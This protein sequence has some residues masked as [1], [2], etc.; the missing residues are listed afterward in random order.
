M[1]LKHHVTIGRSVLAHPDG[2]HR[3]L[4]RRLAWMVSVC[5]IIFSVGIVIRCTAVNVVQRRCADGRLICGSN[6]VTIGLVMLAFI[7]LF[8]SIFSL[9]LYTQPLLNPLRNESAKEYRCIAART[10]VT[11]TFMLMSSLTVCITLAVLGHKLVTDRKFIVLLVALDVFLNVCLLNA[12]WT[13]RYYCKIAIE[14]FGIRED[15]LS[16]DSRGLR[17]HSMNPM[18]ASWKISK[19]QGSSVSHLD[20]QS[21]SAIGKSSRPVMLSD[22]KI[23]DRSSGTKTTKTQPTED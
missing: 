8:V 4:R 11:S 18:E 15:S 17:Q 7:E 5:M 10:L 12:T 3:T 9:T 22:I 14:T 13:S 16:L 23:G 2:M 19:R 1:L 20:R 21:A 6:D